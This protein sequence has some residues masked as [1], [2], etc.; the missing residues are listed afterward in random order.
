M[1]HA[2]LH[3]DK[4]NE[5]Y[6]IPLPNVKVQG[7]ITGTPYP[8]LTGTYHI[9]SS[10]G[11]VAEVDFSGK[12][13]F[14]MSGRKNQVQAALYFSKDRLRNEPLYTITGAWN[15]E[16]TIR[17][18]T[19]GSDIETFDAASQ[20][21][22]S[23]EVADASIQDPWESRKAWSGTIQ[24]LH[25]GDMQA[26]SDAKSKIERGQ[27]EMRREEEG[28]ASVWDP[29]FFARERDDERY[30]Q[31]AAVTGISDEEGN[32]HGFWRFSREKAE[33]ARKPYHGQLRPENSSK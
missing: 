23:L 10:S 16:F 4:H 32:Q 30:R 26:A 22:T 2:I 15:S 11:F 20:H 21:P 9:V 8:E 12:K 31:L 13:L 3:L 33:R 27:R 29:V 18:E 1:G 28:K 14:G 17:D 6:L 7:L 5:D 24:A 19:T 25:S